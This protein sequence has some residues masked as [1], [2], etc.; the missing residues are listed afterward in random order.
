MKQ[1]HFMDIQRLKADGGELV[2]ENTGCFHVGDQ[3]QITTKIDG[4]NASIRYDE[5]TGSLAAFSRKQPLSFNNTLNGFW[6]YIQS[7][8]AEEYSKTPELVIYGEWCGARNKI[9][10]EDD[11]KGGWYVYDIYDVDKAEYKPQDFVKE[12]CAE[13]NLTYVNEL[14]NGKFISWDHV[15]GFLNHHWKSLGQEEGIVVKNQTMLNDP[16]TR[17]P[18]YLKIVNDSFSEVMK[19]KVKV[20]DP[21]KEAEKERIQSL[22]ESI[23]TERRVEKK[24]FELRDSGELPE[25]LQPEDMKLVAKLLPKI[26]YDDCLKEEEETVKACGEMFGKMCGSITMKIA[27][28]IICGS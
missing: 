17:E 25:K 23:V 20:V 12:F 24:L 8:N 5:E 1:K 7:L 27:R 2:Q 11:V 22:V 18:F 4:A 6:N 15:K 28:Q 10:Y 16:N 19:N 21:E 14:Y 26:I 9:R 13:H 3:I